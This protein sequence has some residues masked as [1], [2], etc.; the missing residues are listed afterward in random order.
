LHRRSLSDLASDLNL[1]IDA[2]PPEL[3]KNSKVKVG[4]SMGGLRLGLIASEN[5]KKNSIALSIPYDDR[6]CLT[7]SSATGTVLKGILP[8]GYDGWTGDAGLIAMLILNELAKASNSDVSGAAL[9]IDLPKRDPATSDLMKA[10]VRCLPSPSEMAVDHPLLWDEDDQ[11]TLQGSSTKKIYGVLDDIEEDSN[12]LTERIWSNDRTKFPETITLDDGE[13]DRPCFSPEG[14]AWAVAIANSRSSFVD[15]TLRLIPV[16][17]LANHDEIG[18]EEIRGGTTGTFGTIKCAKIGSGRNRQY[19]QGDEVFVS[20]GPKSAADYLL[21]HGF[22]PPGATSAT[23]V[24][25]LSFAVD[26]DDRFYGDKLDVLEFETFG[27]VPMEPSQR[28]DVVYEAGKEGEPDPALLQFLR[29][30]LLGG[31]DA[32]MLESIFRKEVWEFM[33]VPVS[34]E[35]E[36]KVCDAI[37]EACTAALE[38]MIGDESSDEEVDPLSPA[39]LCAAVRTAEQRALTR[40]VEYVTRDK[41]SLDLKEYYQSRRLR[42]LGLES[43]WNEDDENSDVGWGQTRA[44]GSGDLDW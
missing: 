12:W 14:Y 18:T 22:V 43:N 36:G 37:I 1:A 25:E 6:I 44:P 28:F 4:P 31:K 42:D 39:A 7:S 10:W 26:T 23:S 30:V 16:L 32:F 19:K 24:S 38:E 3:F 34:E 41:E 20:Y 27:E 15:A 33:S 13:L 35:N 40:T 11:E 29:L 5:V 9:G 17:D 21:E 2:C 8:E